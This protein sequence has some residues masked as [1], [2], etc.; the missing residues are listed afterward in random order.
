M[1]AFDHP[2]SISLL[3]SFP[4]LLSKSAPSDIDMHLFVINYRHGAADAG[5]RFD[6]PQHE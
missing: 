6:Q 1:F 2:V 3:F 4:G 5:K